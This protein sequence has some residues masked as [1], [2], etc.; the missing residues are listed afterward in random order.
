MI[1]CPS[2]YSSEWEMFYISEP[3]S[4]TLHVNTNYLL[5]T[6]TN[7][8]SLTT[9]MPINKGKVYSSLFWKITSVSKAVTLKPPTQHF[10]IIYT[11]FNPASN[12][13]I[14]CS[15]VSCPTVY[16]LKYTIFY[17]TFLVIFSWNYNCN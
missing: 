15:R 8:C 6:F 5:Q 13:F 16:M 1:L 11:C 9:Q 2:R 17:Y 10:N 7:P 4:S 12:F 14:L 3:T